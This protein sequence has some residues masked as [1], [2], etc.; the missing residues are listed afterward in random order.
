M[1]SRRVTAIESFGTVL[2]DASGQEQKPVDVGFLEGRS[3]NSTVAL[4]HPRQ[5]GYLVGLWNMC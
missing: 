2:P 4:L 1:V 3:R 5:V